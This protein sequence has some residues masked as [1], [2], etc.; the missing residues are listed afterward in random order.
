M[1]SDNVIDQGAYEWVSHQNK[2]PALRHELEDWMWAGHFHSSRESDSR[3]GICKT[4]GSWTAK[5]VLII[6]VVANHCLL[7]GIHC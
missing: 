2:V 6:I 3:W 4:N 7:Q 1:F 5:A